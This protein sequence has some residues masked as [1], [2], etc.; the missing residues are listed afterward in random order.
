MPQFKGFPPRREKLV[1]I[2]AVFFKELLPEIDDMSELKTTLYIFWFYAHQEDT[3]KFITFHDF[4]ED[5]E[6]LRGLDQDLEKAKKLLQNS[7]SSALERGTIITYSPDSKELP[8]CYY[9]L[10]TPRNVACIK[11][12]E[13]GQLSLDS[14]NQLPAK[15]ELERPTIFNLYEEN[16]GPLTPMI[17]DTL[18]DAEETY[19]YEWIEDA[20]RIA[21]EKNVRRWRYIEAILQSWKE[22]GRNGSYQRDSEEDRRRYIEGKFADFIEH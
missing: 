19:S 14:I 9:F 21:V 2:P 17:A 20:I 12:L 22:K 16:I 7:L 5:E 18:K 1:P 6:F 11:G 4:L 15:L 10:N 8:S 13:S 3:A